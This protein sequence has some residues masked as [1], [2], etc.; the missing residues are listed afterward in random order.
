MHHVRA[1]SFSTNRS[2]RALSQGKTGLI[3]F[4]IPFVLGDYYS[5]ILSGATEALHEQEMRA[6]LCPTRHEHDRE[7]ALVERL[8]RGT[9]DGAILV[10]PSESAAELRELETLG[11][12][13]RRRR[14]A[15]AARRAHPRRLGHA[16]GRR[17]R[18]HRPPARA[19]TPPHRDHRGT[20][21]LGR[22]RGAGERL[23]GGARGRRRAPDAGARRCGELRDRR[24]ATEAAHR[25]LALDE[26]PTAIFASN[27]NMA[28]GALR[29]A[30][31]RNL[32]VPDDLSVVGFDDSELS[33][34]VTP[35]SPRSASRSRR[36]AA[37]RS[38]CSR[39]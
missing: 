26:P 5:W 32:R 10:L 13:L 19:R 4:T 39:G 12:P 31:E 35:T 25:L 17:A 29:A 1:L 9:T 34:V 11:L 22:E 37:W 38:A 28:I 6:V 30:A 2:A 8:L 21:G 3:G 36:W 23:P 15:D 27:D 18:G 24:T 14:P 20:Q 16:L 33:R 7:A